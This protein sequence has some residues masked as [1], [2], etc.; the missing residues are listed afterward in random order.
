M[1][2]NCVGNGR[3]RDDTGQV[4]GTDALVDTFRVVG[5]AQKDISALDVQH[6]CYLFGGPA[7]DADFLYQQCF[8]MMVSQEDDQLISSYV[9]NKAVCEY[10][11]GRLEWEYLIRKMIRKGV[12]VHN[13]VSD[14]DIDEPDECY[15]GDSMEESFR[16]MRQ[17]RHFIHGT[18]LDKLFV[19]TVSPYEAELAAQ[20]WLFILRAEGFDLVTYLKEE[21]AIHAAHQQLTYS[22]K[23][24]TTR[25]QLV[26]SLGASPTCWW[27]W[28]LDPESGA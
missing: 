14:A 13:R 28:L 21:I 24:G 11:K 10:G 2:P 1:S 22:G 8:N 16:L 5:R 4:L 3:I 23:A 7:Q 12:D 17:G 9:L 18:P 25:R 26:F 19:N 27:E 15:V 6:L 20:G